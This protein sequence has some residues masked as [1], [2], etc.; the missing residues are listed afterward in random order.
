MLG[1]SDAPRQRAQ[2]VPLAPGA[3]VLRRHGAAAGGA[4]RG[5]LLGRKTCG[6]SRVGSMPGGFPWEQKNQHPIIFWLVEFE[7][8]GTQN[9]AN[10]KGKRAE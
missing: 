7:G 6:E 5:E 10:K 3:G 2:R 9:P 4:Q 1:R 8:I